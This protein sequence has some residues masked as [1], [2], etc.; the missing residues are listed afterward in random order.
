MTKKIDVAKHTLVPKHSVLNDK[1]KKELL[2]T[3]QISFQEIPKILK[4]D[5]AL[6]EIKAKAGDIIKIERIDNVSGE[7][8]YYR[9]VINA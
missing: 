9:G 1:D 6:R 4:N 5:S 2:E 7:N 8:T 3:Y